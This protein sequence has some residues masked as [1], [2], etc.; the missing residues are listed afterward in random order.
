MFGCVALVVGA[1]TGH[2]GRAIAV[3]AAFAVGTYLL[4][5]I[6]PLVGSIEW[7][8]KLSPFYHYEV[9]DPLREGLALTHV[10][11]LLGVAV[12]AAVLAPLAFDRRD[13]TS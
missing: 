3:A 1:A 5:A 6:A 12:V 8:Q 7:L 2:R 9:S 10:G 13:L 11:V 4:D